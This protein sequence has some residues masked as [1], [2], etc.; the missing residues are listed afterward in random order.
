MKNAYLVR[1]AAVVSLAA[2]LIGLASMGT[3]ENEMR[4]VIPISTAAAEPAG[5]FPAGYDLQ[6]N[7][8]E[9]EIFEYH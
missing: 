6:P 8:L 5:Y 7:P 2:G 1:T 3:Q 9:P 4:E